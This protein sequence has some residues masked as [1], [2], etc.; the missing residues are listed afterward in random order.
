MLRFIE[1]DLNKIMIVSFSFSNKSRR[2]QK[3][4]HKYMKCLYLNRNKENPYK[5]IY[6]LQFNENI[7]KKLLG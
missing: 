3:K 1:F 5:L 4:T 6:R 7:K 2:R